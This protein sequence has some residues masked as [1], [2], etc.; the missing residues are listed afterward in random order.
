FGAVT[1]TKSISLVAEGVTGGVLSTVN[2]IIVNAG[3]ND[4]VVLK[5]LNINGANSVGSFD[6]ISF[7]AGKVLKVE[8]CHIAQ[9]GRRGISVAPSLNDVQV[10][11]SNTRI[12]AGLSNGV[13][14]TPSNSVKAQVTMENVSIVENVNF[15]LSITAG[16]TVIVRHSTISDN[17]L[18]TNLANIRADGTG[19]G[20]TSI[21]LDDVMVSGSATG[22]LALTGAFVRVNNSSIVQNTAGMTTTGGS[23]Y[24]FGNNRVVNSSF[25]SFTGTILLQ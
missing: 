4:V 14:I 11:V 3:A 8:D 1:I 21:L 2:G 9:F 12:E 25:N 22:I 20:S 17:G 13:V 23:V 15:G 19:G 24:S 10:F 16:A 7:L 5:G 6:G 18:A